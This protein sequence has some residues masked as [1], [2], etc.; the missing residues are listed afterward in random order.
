LHLRRTWPVCGLEIFNFRKYSFTEVSNSK[1]WNKTTNK[2]SRFW[3]VFLWEIFV[4]VFKIFIPE[5][6]FSLYHCTVNH[7]LP[8][9]V[10][11]AF[12]RF[13]NQKDFAKAVFLHYG[14][15]GLW[16]SPGTIVLSRKWLQAI[17]LEERLIV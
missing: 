2:P 13:H 9:E 12:A 6:V 3:I 7:L 5:Y 1:H 17:V 4:D 16:N 8:L 11:V 14:H 15:H 10:P